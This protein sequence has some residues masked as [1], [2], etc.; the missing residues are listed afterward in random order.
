LVPERN[1]GDI[2]DMV[3]G[4]VGGGLKERRCPVDSA[5]ARREDSAPGLSGFPGELGSGFME[6]FSKFIWRS[7]AVE[8]NGLA[9]VRSTLGE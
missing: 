1:G 6:T 5:L 7:S 9:G 3:V 4:P 8:V 2:V